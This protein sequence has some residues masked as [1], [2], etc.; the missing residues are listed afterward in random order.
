MFGREHSQD[1][2]GTLVVAEPMA[3]VRGAH[4]MGDA[5]FGLYLLAMGRGQPRSADA[6]QAL[7]VEAGFEA[8]RS[9]RTNLP[10]HCGVLVA[11]KPA[12]P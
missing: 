5:Y 2:S 8:V 6:L 3:G 1:E 12:Q 10:L 11:R 9:R 4:A 7:L